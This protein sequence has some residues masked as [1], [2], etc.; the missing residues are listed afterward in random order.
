M[1]GEIG[2][3]GAS[4]TDFLLLLSELAG[5]GSETLP[6]DLEGSL[7]AGELSVPPGPTSDRN[8]PAIKSGFL[9]LASVGA[10]PKTKGGCLLNGGFLKL[11]T[12]WWN[13]RP[14]C[15]ADKRA[16]WWRMWSQ[17]TKEKS[18]KKKKKKAQK[19]VDR[20]GTWTHAQFPEPG[21]WY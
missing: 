21:D 10:V 17:P 7:E 11:S 16:R 2:P 20:S 6:D 15:F 12:A 1:A 8:S 18:L 13:V 5:D 14:W 3:A 19:S 9:P 4:V